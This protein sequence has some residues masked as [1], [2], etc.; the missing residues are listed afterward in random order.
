MSQPIHLSDDELTVVMSAARVLPVA[1]RDPFLRQVAEALATQPV[2]G[3]G[4]V[5]RICRE[6]QQRLWR[7]PDLRIGES[8]SRVHA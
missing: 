5:S 7:A 6:V 8:R 1:D 4:V 2:L 3:P